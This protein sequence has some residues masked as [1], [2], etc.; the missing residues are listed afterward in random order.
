MSP[1]AVNLEYIKARIATARKAAVRPASE[2]HLIAVSKTHPATLIEQA[3]SA[4]HRLFGESKVQEAQAKWP[5]LR[6][7]FGDVELHMVG[8]LQTNKVKE[9]VGL[10]DAIHSV[11][12]IKLANAIASERDK[13]GKNPKL[14]VQVNIG[15]EAQ[16]SGVSPRETLA[17]VNDVRALELNLVGLMC[18]PPA[19]LAPAPYFGLL[20]T[21]ADEAGLPL[22]SMGMSDDF[23]IAIKFGATH[24]RVGT[25][26]FGARDY[27][28]A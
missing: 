4:G 9:A 25:A 22:L 2:T 24:V 16:K 11:D 13:Q 15:E 26:I 3:L 7:Q 27:S 20:K 5:Q 19:E 23:D 17:L 12:R 18:V 10:F 21:L 1:I 8:G 6:E 14:F 28:K